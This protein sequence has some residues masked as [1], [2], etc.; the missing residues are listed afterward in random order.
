M[1][2]IDGSP[3]NAERNSNLPFGYWDTLERRGHYLLAIAVVCVL[4]LFIIG[5]GAA[6]VLR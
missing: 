5:C 6:G 4:A 1:N 2:R 3:I